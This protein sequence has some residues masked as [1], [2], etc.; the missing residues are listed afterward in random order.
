MK[1]KLTKADGT[2][3]EAEGTAEE[4]EKIVRA[5]EPKFQLSP[6]TFRLLPY[7]IVPNQPQYPSYTPDCYPSGPAYVDDGLHKVY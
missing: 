6:D 1:L 4:L 2:V 5:C 3:I 7:W